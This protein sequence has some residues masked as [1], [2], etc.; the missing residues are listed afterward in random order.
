MFTIPEQTLFGLD[1]GITKLR[2]AQIRTI[3]RSRVVTALREAEIPAGVIVDGQ[4]ADPTQLSRLVA[5]LYHKKEHS[6]RIGGNGV[7]SALPESKTFMKLI[8]LDTR[9]PEKIK[10]QLLEEIPRHIPLPL[11]EIYYDWQTVAVT[12]RGQSHGLIGVAPRPLVDAYLAVL[13][14]AGLLPFAL[15]IEAS[16]ITR[17][18]LKEKSAADTGAQ[19]I[20]DLGA[21]RTGLIVVRDGI[22]QCTVSLPISGVRITQTIAATLNI[23]AQEAEEAKLVCGL[24]PDR[25]HGALKRVL[26]TTFDDLCRK[27]ETAIAFYQENFP[28][29]LP[30]GEVVLTGGGANFLHLDRLLAE[31]LALP[32]RLGNPLSNVELGKM[33]VGASALQSYVTAIGLALRG[34]QRDA[35]I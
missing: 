21:T 6:E 7:I 29:H 23:N 5:A 8:A 33:K 26:R 20:I 14:G 24:D 32:V 9:D 3:R 1:I 13:R 2:L 11:E 18:L 30:I 4:I 17:C 10:T 31:H 35:V 19:I 25:C 16:P 34:T 27:I 15:E 28:D 12:P 22:I